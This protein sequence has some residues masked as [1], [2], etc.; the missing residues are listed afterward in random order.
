MIKKNKKD[1]IADL[2]K[3][4]GAKISIETKVKITKEN[5]GIFCESGIKKLTHEILD[6]PSNEKYFSWKEKT[7]A[8]VSDASSVFNFG[9]VHSEAVMPFLESKSVL[10]KQ[11]AGINAVPIILDTQ[12]VSEIIDAIKMISKSFSAINIEGMSSP[13]C[14]EIEEI[15]NKE[16]NIPVV[17]GWQHETAIVVLAGLINAHKVVNKNIKQSRIAIVGSGVSGIAIAKLLKAY[18]VGDIV[19]VDTNGIIGEHRTDLNSEKELLVNVTNNEKRTGGILEAM[20]GADV[21]IGVSVPKTVRP[22]FVRMMAQNPIVFSLAD[23]LPEIKPEIALSAGAS[24][25]ATGSFDYVNNINNALVYP[26][27][28]KGMIENNISNLTEEIEIRIAESLAELIKKPS[29][30]KILPTVFNKSVVK[31]VYNSVL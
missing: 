30:K 9:N 1:E 31:S 13:K 5:F 24:V 4:I 8:I 27:L 19:M 18:G 28:F 26:G 16:L 17:H 21:F 15:L 6:F 29:Q 14:F 3:K 20:V 2:H 11:F 10:F 7:I 12:N 22:E 25:V 23:S